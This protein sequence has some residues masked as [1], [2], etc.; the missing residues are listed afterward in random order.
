[1]RTGPAEYVYGP[2][3]APMDNPFF[4]LNANGTLYG[5]SANGNTEIIAK[6]TLTSTIPEPAPIA[7]AGGEAGQF[8]SCGA[9]LN[10]VV[11]DGDVIRGWYHAE[12]DCDYDNNGQTYKNIGYCESHDGG[13]TFT[14]PNYPNNQALTGS[15]P[16]TSALCVGNADQSVVDGGDGYYYMFFINW[17]NYGYCVARSSEKG[18]PGSWTKYYEGTWSEPGLGGKATGIA[19]LNSATIVRHTSGN[20]ISVGSGPGISMSF[21][22]DPLTWVHLAE[23]V[24]FNQAPLQW[25][26]P[27]PTEL[28]GYP[29]FVPLDGGSGDIGDQFWLYY[30]YI[31]PGEDYAKRYLVRRQVTFTLDNDTSIAPQA[32]VE[33][34]RYTS[35]ARTWVTTTLPLPLDASYVYADSMGYLLTTAY[36]GSIPIYDCYIPGWD[37]HMLSTDINSCNS[38]GIALLRQLGWVY[39]TEQPATTV[40]TLPL[41]RCFNSQTN[42]HSVSHR[43]DCEENGSMEFILGWSMSE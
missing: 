23:P 31:Q 20:L 1:V 12:T 8:D 3:F 30:V 16:P 34:S 14:K 2:R 32:G 21:G 41:Y 37:D 24:L 38:E 35:G 9:W 25:S 39:E 28:V 40:A 13:L 4:S 26:R 19:N 29:N 5:Y 15:L 36:L 18:V 11:V 6:G 10:N 27:A 33:L 43:T 22:T 42:K 17:D 7:L